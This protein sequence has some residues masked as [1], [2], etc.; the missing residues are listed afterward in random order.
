VR[1]RPWSRKLEHARDFRA[2]PSSKDWSNLL[3]A[4]DDQVCQRDNAP[5]ENE[6]LERFARCMATLRTPALTASLCGKATSRR[7]ML[8]WRRLSTEQPLQHGTRQAS[9]KLGTPQTAEHYREEE[10]PK[11]RWPT[12]PRIRTITETRLPNQ[13][14]WVRRRARMRT[15]CSRRAQATEPGAVLLIFL[16]RG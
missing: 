11:L 3:R 16:P 10:T 2:H 1:E 13:R 6:P 5:Q 7:S 12:D 4:R 14:Y 15:V 9:K 8:F